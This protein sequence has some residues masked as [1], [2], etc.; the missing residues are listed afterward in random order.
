[1]NCPAGAIVLLTLCRF[2][3]PMKSAWAAS[4]ICGQSVTTPP[5]SAIRARDKTSLNAFEPWA[6]VTL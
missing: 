5:D 4:G 2:T 1:M 6:V 3:A